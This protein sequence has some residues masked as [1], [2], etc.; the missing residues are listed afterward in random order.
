MHIPVVL[1]RDVGSPSSITTEVYIHNKQQIQT[2]LKF[3]TH[4]RGYVLCVYV[5]VCLCVCVSVC[6]C[7]CVCMCVCAHSFTYVCYV[8]AGIATLVLSDQNANFLAVSIK[9]YYLKPLD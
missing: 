9:V 3:C 4:I 5:C 6:V 7:V 2:L 8:F 1:G